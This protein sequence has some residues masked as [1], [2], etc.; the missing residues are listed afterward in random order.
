MRQRSTPEEGAVR[1]Y[2]SVA[3]THI[4]VVVIARP[5]EIHILRAHIELRQDALP[6]GRDVAALAPR[7]ADVG[8]EH[9]LPS[10]PASV[11]SQHFLTITDVT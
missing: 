10:L 9:L 4:E 6:R 8:I 7:V 2:G 3:G 11:A 1:L 5:R